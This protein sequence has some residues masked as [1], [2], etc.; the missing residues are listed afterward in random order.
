MTFTSTF[1]DRASVLANLV[2]SS[3]TACERSILGDALCAYLDFLCDV[4][5]D[6]PL[7]SPRFSHIATDLTIELRQWLRDSRL[8]D[9]VWSW[10]EGLIRRVSVDCTAKVTFEVRILNGLFEVPIL[11]ARDSEGLSNSVRLLRLL[12]DRET[13]WAVINGYHDW[14]YDAPLDYKEQ[15]GCPPTADEFT[16]MAPEEV[17]YVILDAIKHDVQLVN[18]RLA[19]MGAELLNINWNSVERWIANE[20]V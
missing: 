12:A 13:A 5:S 8:T 14:L 9:C 3:K 6:S 20:L 18:D 15:I 11:S 4:R 7:S 19:H 17:C 10:L 16:D 1:V 2:R